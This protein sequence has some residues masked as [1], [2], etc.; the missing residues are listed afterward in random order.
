MRVK[1]LVSLLLPEAQNFQQT[2]FFIFQIIKYKSVRYLRYITEFLRWWLSVIS[3]TFW[4]WNIMDR[5]ILHT[6]SRCVFAVGDENSTALLYYF[7]FQ[8]TLSSSAS[9]LIFSVPSM[10]LTPILWTCQHLLSTVS[11]MGKYSVK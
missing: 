8:R 1:E 3:E 9:I 4:S 10:Y 11:V 6:G 7:L 5:G 2:S